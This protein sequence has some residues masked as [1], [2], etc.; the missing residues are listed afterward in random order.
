CGSGTYGALTITKNNSADVTVQSVDPNT[1]MT[2]GYVQLANANHWKFQGVHFNDDLQV[3]HSMNITFTHN[4]HEHGQMR[5]C[6]T[7]GSCTDIGGALGNA[8]ILVDHDEFTNYNE[9]DGGAEGRIEIYGDRT[10]TQPTDGFVIQ[11][12]LFKGGYPD[13]C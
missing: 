9:A 13:S 12:S 1:P 5:L 4:L 8:N 10:N 11:Y 7:S 2:L 3:L 6:V